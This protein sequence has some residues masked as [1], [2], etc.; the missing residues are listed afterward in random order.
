MQCNCSFCWM[1]VWFVALERIDWSMIQHGYTFSTV[2]Y[3][4]H[5]AFGS[6]YSTVVILSYVGVYCTIAT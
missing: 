1:E 6:E 4:S 5:V 3:L 2:L